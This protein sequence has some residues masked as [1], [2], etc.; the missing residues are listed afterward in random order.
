M[1]ARDVPVSSQVRPREVPGL[2]DF[3][4]ALHD[5]TARR[6]PLFFSV[7]FQLLFLMFEMG[8]KNARSRPSGNKY[9]SS[10][11]TIVT[12]LGVNGET[13]NLR[14]V[15]ISP[16]VSVKL[17]FECRLCWMNRRAYA[18]GINCFISYL[19]LTDMPNTPHDNTP[20]TRKQLHFPWL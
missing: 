11:R 17:N 3:H 18:Q 1:H 7:V 16:Y 13:Q 19:R 2:V 4:A 15:T 10:R 20:A 6:K 14:W 12:D 8:K 5:A 9:C